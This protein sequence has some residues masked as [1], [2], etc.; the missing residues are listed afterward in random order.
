[1]KAYLTNGVIIE[2]NVEEIRKYLDDQIK[3]NQQSIVNIPYMHTDPNLYWSNPE[4]YKIV[5]STT[6]IKADNTNNI[7]TWSKK[8]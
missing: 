3:E 5:Y 8:N 7:E 1:M 6:S 2:G 4:E